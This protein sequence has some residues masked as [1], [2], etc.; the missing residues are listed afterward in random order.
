M[1]IILF[2]VW[3]SFG[4]DAATTTYALNH[5]GRE[6]LIPSQNIYVIDSVVS[7]EA[8]LTMKGLSRLNSK[9]PLAAKVLGVGMI[10]LRSAIVYHNVNQLR[11]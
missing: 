3:L 8:W 4:A 6:V 7:G 9:H 5:G 1:K 11:K 2:G 10:G